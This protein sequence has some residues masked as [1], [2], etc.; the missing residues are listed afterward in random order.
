MLPQ[1]TLKSPKIRHH[2]T[3]ENFARAVMRRYERCMAVK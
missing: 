1:I 2:M 3:T